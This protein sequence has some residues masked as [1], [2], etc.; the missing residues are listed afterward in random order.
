MRVFVSHKR[1][2][3]RGYIIGNNRVMIEAW[4]NLN[5][6][7]SAYLLEGGRGGGTRYH[8]GRHVRLPTETS[9]INP[10]RYYHVLLSGKT[11]N[12]HNAPLYHYTTITIYKGI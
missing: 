7:A 6:R 4:L 11:L 10:E 1:I 3:C 2:E 8:T 12:F 9:R 5:S